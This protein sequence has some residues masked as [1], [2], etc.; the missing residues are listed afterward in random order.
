MIKHRKKKHRLPRSIIRDR[1]F[2]EFKGDILGA[3]DIPLHFSS[4]ACKTIIFRTVAGMLRFHKKLI[5]LGILGD[6]CFSKQTRGFVSKLVTEVHGYPKKGAEYQYFEVD[7]RYFAL[8]CLVEGHLDQDIVPHESLHVGFAYDFRKA[9]RNRY[10]DPN[11]DISEERV[12]YPAGVFNRILMRVISREG[13]RC[14]GGD[15]KKWRDTW[16][17]DMRKQHENY[18]HHILRY[19]QDKEDQAYLER[20]RKA[21]A[22]SRKNR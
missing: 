11:E 1:R 9:A 22:R 16:D 17:D 18:L 12:C 3:W 5:K 21:L 10:F 8:C 14:V 19:S 7:P 2:R 6:E 4:L 13:I 20:Y 15:S